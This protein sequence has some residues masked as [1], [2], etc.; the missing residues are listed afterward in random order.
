MSWKSNSLPLYQQVPFDIEHLLH[1]CLEEA[2][3]KLGKGSRGTVFFRADDIGVPGE[4]F[5]K[6]VDLFRRR[7]VPLT[8]SVVPAWLTRPRWQQLQDLCGKDHR[9][10]CWTQH[11]WRHMN[12]EPLG[13]KLEFGPNRSA[14]RKREDLCLGF[15]RL[16]KLM[17]ELFVPAF[18]PPWNRCD[19][20]T[21]I[22]LEGLGYKAL[23]RSL[24]AQP[25]APATIVEY[26]VSVDL[27][28]RK[29]QDPINGWQNLCGELR[30]NLARGFCGIML[31]HQRMNH[32]AFVF[33]DLLLDK[34]EGWRYGRLVHFGTLLE[35]GY[36]TPSPRVS[37]V[38]I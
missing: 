24:D 9:L 11:G 15:H 37:G 23:S 17:G 30:E 29:E 8:L 16:R 32:K 3:A 10:W 33:L 14:T 38:D 5:A 7:R 19:E 34:L 35:E 22:A 13:K 4:G 20:E 6:L 12:H 27:H 18:T 21:L 1:R 36:E 28:T 26:P 31:H 25:P 2:A